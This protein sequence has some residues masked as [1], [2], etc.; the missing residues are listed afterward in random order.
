[1]A[2][3]DAFAEAGSPM[4]MTSPFGKW[5]GCATSL[6]NLRHCLSSDARETAAG[7]PRVIQSWRSK[8]LRA[9]KAHPPPTST[10]DQK[11][12]LAPDA[13]TLKSWK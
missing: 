11:R 9:K 4:G 1:M 6:A 2:I 8:E 7:R 13:L 3:L 5:I 12:T 10:L